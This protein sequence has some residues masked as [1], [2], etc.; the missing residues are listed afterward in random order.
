MKFWDGESIKGND[1]SEIKKLTGKV[2]ID[3]F[4][5]SSKS[6]HEAIYLNTGIERYRLRM[7]GGNPF[8]DE[9][10]HKL[11]GKTIVV[12]GYESG[13]IFVIDSITRISDKKEI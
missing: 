10:L 7:K 11:V 4:A 2:E 8:Y 5:K 3:T 6:E 12:E 13:K 9:S 1:L